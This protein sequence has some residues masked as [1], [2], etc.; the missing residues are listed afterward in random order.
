MQTT[1]TLA[2]LADP[3]IA[4]ADKILRTCVHCGFC[5]ATCPTYVLLGDE[6]DSPRGRIYLIKDMLE[7]DRPA[8]RRGGQAYRPLPVLPVLHDDLPVG[9]AL[10][11]PGR[12]CPRAYREDLSRGRCSTG[13]CARCSRRVLPD[14]RLFRAGAASAA[15][16]AA[17]RAAVRRALGLKPLAAHAA[18]RAGAAAGAVD[19]P[20]PASIRR[21]GPRRGR[22]ALLTGCAQPVLAPRHQ[23]GGDPPAHPARHRG[24]AGRKAKAAAAR[25]SHHMGR[26]EEAL[27]RRARQYR[28]LDRARSTARG[29]TP[30]SSP[31]PAAAPR[32][33][34][35]ASCCAPIRPMRTR[36]RAVSALAQDISEYLCTLD[37]SCRPR[38]G[39]ARASPITRACSLQHGQKITREPKELLSQAGLRGEGCAG[40]RI[41]A[42]ARPAP[43]TSCSRRSPDGLR[44]RKVANI[45]TTAP[46]VIATGNIGC[47]TQ[48]AA[49][50]AIPVVHTVELLD[51]ATGGPA[52]A[53]L[54]RTGNG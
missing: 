52:P 11:A 39:P 29:S 50:T 20:R 18:A 1:F 45:E 14:P 37:S 35:T 9:R 47:I 38:R 43:T 5:T 44:D 25:S 32:S 53:A 31:R 28:R 17:A 24:R 41:S 51:W 8:D 33:R 49:G 30:S 19:R 10:H 6:L 23:R 16:S 13:C 27:R 40:R 34:T 15:G 42:A 2:Q 36:P 48:I 7:N 26:E 46:D 21:K 3:D 54:E 22:V 4:E 12:P